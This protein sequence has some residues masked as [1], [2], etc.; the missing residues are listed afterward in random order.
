MATSLQALQIEVDRSV[1]LGG[2]GGP[3][4]LLVSPRTLAARHWP[5][6][7][8]GPLHLER[9]IDDVEN[10]M[11]HAGLRYIERGALSATES[12]RQLLPHRFSLSTEF[13]R[14]DVEAEFSRLVAA[15]GPAGLESELAPN[16]ETVAALLLVREVMHHLGF[17]VLRT[18]G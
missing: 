18:D 14:D 16:G 3:V 12:L 15:S 2:V 6:G 5:R 13:S 9:A 8:P 17:N 10:A 1:L 11:E 7:Q 4:A